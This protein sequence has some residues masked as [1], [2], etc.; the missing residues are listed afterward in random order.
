VIRVRGMI[1]AGVYK[2]FG[3]TFINVLRHEFWSESI[4]GVSSRVRYES[5]ADPSGSLSVSVRR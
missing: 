1:L 3:A 2:K 5:S 4:K